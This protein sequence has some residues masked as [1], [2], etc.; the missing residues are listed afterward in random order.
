MM[1]IRNISLEKIR[2]ENEIIIDKIKDFD[3]AINISKHEVQKFLLIF[4]TL[5]ETVNS[6]EG[7]QQTDRI[8]TNAILQIVLKIGDLLKKNIDSLNLP[9]QY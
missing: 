5:M 6:E 3:E 1:K 4:H 7:L 9:T 2:L 8:I